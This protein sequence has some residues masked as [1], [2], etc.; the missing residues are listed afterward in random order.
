MKP[1][2]IRAIAFDAYGTLFDVHAAVR[3]HAEAVGGDVTCVAEAI[4]LDE[5]IGRHFLKAGIGYGGSCLPKDVAALIAQ[6]GRFLA[7][8]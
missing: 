1:T 7:L 5:R 6:E 8:R 4:G 3:H 2:P